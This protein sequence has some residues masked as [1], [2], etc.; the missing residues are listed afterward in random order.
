MSVLTGELPYNKGVFTERRSDGGY[1]ALNRYGHG[2][3]AR[4]YAPA[5]RKARYR[6]GFMGM[7]LNGC[8]WSTRTVSAREACGKAA[9]IER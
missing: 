1:G 9:R 6:T 8:G 2:D 7:Y 5:P 4:C 3:D